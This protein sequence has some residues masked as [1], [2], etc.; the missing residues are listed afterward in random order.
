MYCNIA[1][2]FSPAENPTSVST[3]AN[4]GEIPVSAPTKSWYKNPMAIMGISV[5][6][7]V[8][9]CIGLFVFLTILSRKWKRK[10]KV[11]VHSP[12]IRG[13]R[14]AV[15]TAS[16]ESSRPPTPDLGVIEDLE[17][18]HLDRVLRGI[19]TTEAFEMKRMHHLDF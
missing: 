18:E 15:V 13:S 7:F 4:T 11:N 12:L 19:K 1:F 9:L 17:M 16:A 2:Y 3:E 10:V 6:G 8:V 14:L 5:G